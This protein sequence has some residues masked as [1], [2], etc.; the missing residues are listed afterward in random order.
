[1]LQNKLWPV[2]AFY[3]QKKEVLTF[4]RSGS[5]AKSALC[6]VAQKKQS[7]V[8]WLMGYDRYHYRAALES[9]NRLDNLGGLVSFF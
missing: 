7:V 2:D 3:S 5:Y 9:P 4:T 6:L 8:M 1:M